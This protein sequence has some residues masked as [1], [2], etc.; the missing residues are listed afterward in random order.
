MT[1]YLISYPSLLFV[2]MLTAR[3]RAVQV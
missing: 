3:I 1:S 2:I